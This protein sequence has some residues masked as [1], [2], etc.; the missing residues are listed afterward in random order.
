MSCVKLVK[1]EGLKIYITESDILDGSPVLDIKPYLPYSD[2]FPDVKTGWV[3][4]GLENKFEIDF[5]DAA[6]AKMKWLK[7]QAGI[8]LRSFTRLQLEFNPTD[9][10]RKRIARLNKDFILSYRTWRIL[11]SV[12]AKK[13]AVKITDV[14]SGYSREE[15]LN[16]H[17]DIYA[18]KDLHCLFAKNFQQLQL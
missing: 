16:K 5:D 9:D 4:S 17:T 6:A 11:Y 14:Y 3:K 12:N 13:N 18:D 8:N 2:S 15:L 1:V 7:Q 10:S